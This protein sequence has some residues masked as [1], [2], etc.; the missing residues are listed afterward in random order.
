M[1]KAQAFHQFWSAFGI[2][3]YDVNTVPSGTPMP[4][5][6]YEYGENSIGEPLVVNASLYYRSTSWAAITEKS[7]AISDFIGSGG[8]TVA[9]N[10][11]LMWVVRGDPFAQRM[12]D[13]DTA[14]RRI[15]LT[16]NIEFLSEN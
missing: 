5:I 2:P 9:F 10:D 16:V 4:Y 6:A 12:S 7:K 15:L 8:I 1:N 14:V 3:A 13:P 11:G